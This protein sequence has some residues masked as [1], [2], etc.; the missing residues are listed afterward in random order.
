MENL[1]YASTEFF[2]PLPEDQIAEE[3]QANPLPGPAMT[4][5]ER[6]RQ[7]LDHPVGSPPLEEIVHPGETVCVV[8]SDV[9]RRWQ[10]TEVYLPLLIQRLNRAGIP[11]RDI[12]LISATG[13][14]RA[15]TEE[16]HRALLGEELSRRF[17]LLDHD[18]DDRANLKYMG[19]TRRGTP[20]WLNA[21]AM[22]CD[23]LILTGGVVY[24]FLAGFG[25]GRKSVIP[26]IAGRETINTNHANAMNEGE[27]TGRSPLVGS[28]RLEGNPFHEDLMEA[29]AMARPDFLLNVVADDDQQIVG[30]FAGDWVKAHESAV[31]FVRELFGVRVSRRVPLVLASAG[32]APKDIN[33]YQSSKTLVNALEMVAPGGTIV[34]LSQC[35]E[36]VGS[37]DCEELLCGYDSLAER[38]TALRKHFTIGGYMGYLYEES[39][40]R[41]NLVVVSELDPAR[42]SR[43][44]LHIVP[45]LED[46]LELAS[47]WFG[48]SLDGVD[49]ALMP[50]GAS[51]FP[52]QPADPYPGRCANHYRA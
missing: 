41:Y 42:F 13:T 40:Q 8:L 36:G 1:K 39:A 15:Q 34:M 14:H 45:T 51:T 29:A 50:H 4:Q 16:E 21:R 27:G 44:S 11:D 24:H 18:C 38:E 33:L 17:T 32:G 10:H 20:V 26:G 49:T 23:R 25:G 9:T 28:G 37:A 43:T 2:V 12:C 48:G 22:A 7:A 5:E 46:A 52:I 3:V 31:E 35:P 30:A 6:L 19:A 47:D